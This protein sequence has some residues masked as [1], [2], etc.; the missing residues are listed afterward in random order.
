L[1]PLDLDESKGV[2]F[3]VVALDGTKHYWSI[4]RQ[5]T[6][7]SGWTLALL[8]AKDRRQRSIIGDLLRHVERDPANR[9]TFASILP[10]R[11]LIELKDAANKSLLEER[12]GRSSELNTAFRKYVLPLFQEDLERA[13]AFLGRL[14]TYSIDEAQLRERVN[15]AIRKLFYSDGECHL[16][17]DDI[18]L[19]LADLLINNI[20]S[21]V[22]RDSILK[23]MV[24]HGVRL[25]DWTI[26]K[27]V[28]DRIKSICLEYTKPL[29]EG[30]INGTFLPLTDSPS[31]V[32]IDCKSASQKLLV[33]GGAGGGKSTTLASV[34][35]QQMSSGIPVL[36]LRFD[37][38]QE[39]ILTTT[40]LGRKLLLPESPVLV[41]A[42]VASGSQSVLIIVWLSDLP[43]PSHKE[44]EL[45]HRLIDSVP[46]LGYHVR[47]ILRGQPAWFDLL[48]NAG[49]FDMALSSGD[50][51]QEQEAVWMLR[52]HR[53]LEERSSRVAEILKMY[54][55]SGGSWPRYLHQIF[56]TGHGLCNRDMFD[57]FLSLIDDGT[58]DDLLFG[59]APIDRDWWSALYATSKERPDLACE[60]IGHWFDRV[61]VTWRVPA[62]SG[63]DTDD[64][65]SVARQLE[66]EQAQC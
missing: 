65:A 57:L 50:D 51:A 22:D 58:L 36:A 30:R 4:K 17:F 44:L 18:R 25:C 15:F 59:A 31:F 49:F 55:S 24:A 39:G 20:N 42:G 26:E 54:R 6:R 13:R 46:E 1:E 21:P 14:Q 12:L 23:A 38:L 27:S 2:E 47:G 45:L 7:A 53:T 32:G 61:L 19:R 41:L 40:E 34:V 35:D 29:L 33:I 37:Q 66:A 64:L 11:D 52:F 56:R 9:C 60:A 62:G 63:A 28:R 16:S 48:D 5:T 43:D 10:C 3:V 8:A